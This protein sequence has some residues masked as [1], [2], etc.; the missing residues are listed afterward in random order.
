MKVDRLH[1]QS[2]HHAM[3]SD[4]T[5]KHDLRCMVVEGYTWMYAA[6]PRRVLKSKL[7]RLLACNAS[8]FL[9]GIRCNMYSCIPRLQGSTA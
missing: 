6:S 7:L 5:H 2:S 3:D 8:G 9:K 1:S 4:K